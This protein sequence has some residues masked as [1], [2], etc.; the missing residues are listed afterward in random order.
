[1]VFS[2]KKQLSGYQSWLNLA[3]TIELT[4]LKALNRYD[5]ITFSFV[6][7]SV[8][9][10]TLMISNYNPLFALFALVMHLYLGI[11]LLKARTVVVEAL[12]ALFNYTKLN[13]NVAKYLNREYSL[14]LVAQGKKPLS[15]EAI[16]NLEI[17]T[18][19][20]V[21]GEM[22]RGGRADSIRRFRIHFLKR[23]RTF[24][25]L[26]YSALIIIELF[27]IL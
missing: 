5:F 8:L 10:I 25:H 24:F 12:D 19:K 9:F 15:E 2:I 27:V 13:T 11:N 3:E 22:T 6:F 18:R 4:E 23:E 7:F 16:E 21:E 20:F 14:F 17:H 26:L 1:M